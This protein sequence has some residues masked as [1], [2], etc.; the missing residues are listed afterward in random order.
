MSLSLEAHDLSPPV[1]WRFCLFVPLVIFAVIFLLL[2]FVSIQHYCIICLK[3]MCRSTWSIQVQQNVWMLTLL[4]AICVYISSLV[5]IL[6]T[7]VYFKL[8]GLGEKDGVGGEFRPVKLSQALYSVLLRL[9]GHVQTDDWSKSFVSLFEP[10]DDRLA[11]I[12]VLINCF[13]GVTCILP[14][15]VSCVKSLLWF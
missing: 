10:L 13:R 11:N 9:A 1:L 12:P 4:A 5:L 8:I 14:T 6:L 3:E 7:W 2:L 15:A